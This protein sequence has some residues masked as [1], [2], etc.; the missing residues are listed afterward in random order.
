LAV[1]SVNVIW[2]VSVQ[3]TSILIVGSLIASTIKNLDIE[4][5]YKQVQ[6]KGKAKRKI[7]A[8]E[9]C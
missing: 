6:D 7:A 2:L 5:I 1:L 3:E 9:K 8:Y 4:K